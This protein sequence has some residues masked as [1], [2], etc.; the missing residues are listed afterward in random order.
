MSRE[1]KG[2][3]ARAAGLS[4]LLLAA[5]FLSACAG[6]APSPDFDLQGHRGAR[7]LFPENTQAAFAGALANGVTTL[8][9]DTVVTRDGVVVV[10]HDRRLD[11]A[12]TRGADGAWIAN[13]EP[14]VAA[15]TFA[16]LQK[17]DVG[18]VRPHGK[19]AERFSGQVP[20]DGARIPRLH[21]V[22]A[23]AEARSGGTMRYNIETKRSPLAPEEAPAPE[24]FAAAVVAV[25]ANAGL[26]R[27]GRAAVQ[28]FDWRTLEVVQRIAPAVPT[29]CLTV[30]QD[31]QDTVQRGQPG[32]SPW[33]AGRDVDAFAGSVP[34]MAAAAGCA[35]WSPYFKDLDATALVDARALGLRVV[36]WT[37]NEPDD[38]RRLVVLG[39]DGIITDYPD[40]LRAVMRRRG[41]TLPPAFPPEG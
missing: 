33:T 16:E 11:A 4:T 22:L 18:R 2:L 12:R 39:V 25:L 15:L 38:M 29:V 31:W 20:Q 7:G 6:P 3:R 17:Y 1:P 40:R 24:A 35:V 13:P 10:H 9:M 26:D 21:D 34:H 32:A 8:E 5:G 36:V 27:T 14:L 19:T 28:S 37:V 30:E 23:R 41:M